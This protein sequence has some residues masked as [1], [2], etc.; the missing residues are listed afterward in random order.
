MTWQIQLSGK[1]ATGVRAE[2]FDVD[3]FDTPPALVRDLRRKHRLVLCYLSAGTDEDYLLP[4]QR[5]PPE[6][7]GSHLA[8]HHDERWL[9]VRAIDKLKPVIDRR[10]DLCK[11][12]GYTGVDFDNVDGYSNDSGFALSAA[13]QLRYNRYLAAA[14]HARGLAAGL[15]N[16]VNQVP[17]LAGSFDFAINEQCFQYHECGVLQ[18]EFVRHGKPVFQIEYLKPVRFCARAKRL[19]FSSLYKRPGLGA[20]RVSC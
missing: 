3:L 4:T 17:K 19:G 13:D 20:Y 6:T 18:R 16:D 1:I 5:F 10:L 8:D 2:L 11:R 9:D 7:R 12:N 15:K 14:A